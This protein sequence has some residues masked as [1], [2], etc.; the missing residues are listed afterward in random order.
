MHKSMHEKY[1]NT[2]RPWQNGQKS[3]DTPSG[4]AAE[5]TRVSSV[6]SP[7]ATGRVWDMK[8]VFFLRAIT[9]VIMGKF[10]RRVI[11]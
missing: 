9:R 2:C 3:Y 1:E 4:R 6:L 7:R 10:L 5:G 8:S 11:F